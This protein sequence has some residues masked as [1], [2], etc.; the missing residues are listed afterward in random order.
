M[1]LAVLYEGLPTGEVSNDGGGPEISQK[2]ASKAP[3]DQEILTRGFAEPC[4]VKVGVL[5]WW[6]I[7]GA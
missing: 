3:C 7:L 1:N 6:A 5:I 2:R 4:E